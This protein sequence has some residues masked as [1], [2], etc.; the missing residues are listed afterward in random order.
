MPITALPALKR[1]D[2]WKL[3]FVARESPNGPTLDL[4]GCAAAL[5]LRHPQTDALVAV[6]DSVILTPLTGTVLATFLPATTATVPVGAY[7][8]DLEITFADGQ[9]R[10]SQTLSLPVI[11]DY[12]RP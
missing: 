7:L 12:T 5:Q 1:G 4:T 3:T 6:P 11:A 8:T 2:T 9:V 10:S